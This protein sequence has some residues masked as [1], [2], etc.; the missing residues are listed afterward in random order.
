[1]HSITVSFEALLKQGIVHI[2]MQVYTV[3]SKE[4]YYDVCKTLL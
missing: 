1:M 3:I 4:V 2:S